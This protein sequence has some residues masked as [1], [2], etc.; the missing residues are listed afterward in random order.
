MRRRSNWVTL[1]F[2]KPS[3]S[4]TSSHSPAKS[5]DDW[6]L[7]ED[8]KLAARRRPAPPGPLFSFSFM[9]ATTRSLFFLNE[10]DLW[11]GAGRRRAGWSD[12]D[13]D[14]SSRL[15]SR[16]SCRLS[17][18]FFCSVRS[19][20]LFML[21]RYRTISFS[22]FSS[23]FSWLCVTL[24]RSFW[25]SISF[26][27]RCMFWFSVFSRIMIFSKL[28]FSPLSSF[29]A[30]C[31]CEPCTIDA[32][33][34]PFSFVIFRLNTFQTTSLPQPHSNRCVQCCDLTIKFRFSA[35][36]C[37]WIFWGVYWHRWQTLSDVTVAMTAIALCTWEIPDCQGS[38]LRKGDLEAAHNWSPSYKPCD[39]AE[40]V[41]TILERK[42]R[43]RLF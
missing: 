18:S 25:Y 17:A 13:A 23:F 38:A 33:V 14:F 39:D 12:S 34:L 27:L 30:M 5:S 15:A 24:N 9:V 41:I 22:L 1:A 6:L 19:Y 2:R 28:V 35:L 42:S 3:T 21:C 32:A 29:T 31:R 26:S 40:R 43:N 4:V 37:L 36:T 11:G 8:R 10:S 7:V 20:F 16:R